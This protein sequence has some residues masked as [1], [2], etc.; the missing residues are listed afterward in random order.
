MFVLHV[1]VFRYHLLLSVGR[2]AFERFSNV[3]IYTK[4]IAADAYVYVFYKVEKE[5]V[6]WQTTC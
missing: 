3:C 4:A 5:S 2:V 6:S 1:L